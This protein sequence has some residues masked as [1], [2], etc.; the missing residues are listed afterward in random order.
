LS[1]SPKN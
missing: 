1:A